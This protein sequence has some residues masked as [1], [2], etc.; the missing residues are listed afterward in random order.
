MHDTSHESFM[1]RAIELSEKAAFIEKSGGAF[2][3]VIVKDGKIVGE[4]YNQVIKTNDPTWHAEMHAIREASKTLNTFDLSGCI[5]YTSAE[6][7][8]MCLGAAYWAYI[9]VIYYSAT[10]KDVLHYGNFQDFDMYQDF[11]KPQK[12]RKIPCMNICREES[13][14]VWKKFSAN[15]DKVHY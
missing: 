14:V 6:C 11:Q 7:C 12:E 13:L 4:G 9:D 1:K 2:G 10:A 15:P 3:C 5:M 8:P